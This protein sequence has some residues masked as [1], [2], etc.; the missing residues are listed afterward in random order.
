MKNNLQNNKPL[1]KKIDW[2]KMKIELREK[3]G[4]D[5]F[6]SWIKK[7]ELVDEFHNYILSLSIFF[8]DVTKSKINL[9]TIIAV[10]ILTIIPQKRTVA[11]P[12]IGPLPY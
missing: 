9:V 6:E 5:I 4:N 11:K 10:N 3:F 7:I 8:L 2:E 1:E 12:F